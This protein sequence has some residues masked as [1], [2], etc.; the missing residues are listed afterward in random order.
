MLSGYKMTSISLQKMLLLSGAL[1]SFCCQ[2]DKIHD[3][4]KPRAGMGQAVTAGKPQQELQ[5][6]LQG[7]LNNQNKKLA[8]IA[9]E[10][11]QEG[12]QVNGYKI[13][14]INNNNIIITKAG[15]LKRLYVYQ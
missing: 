5:I 3:P 4:T 10:I 13:I 9:D 1:L 14:K 7:I 8:I 12:A 2:A 15:V 6:R 11:F